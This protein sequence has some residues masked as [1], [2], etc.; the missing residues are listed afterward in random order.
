MNS[1]VINSPARQA[2]SPAWATYQDPRRTYE[3]EH[4]TAFTVT[5]T[6]PGQEPWSFDLDAPNLLPAQSDAAW[7]VRDLAHTPN[8]Q[9]T[10]TPKPVTA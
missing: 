3:R 6:A 9:I 10:V 1:L 2:A 5:I 7:R 4:P 8:L